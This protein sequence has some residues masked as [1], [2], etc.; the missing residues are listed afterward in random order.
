MMKKLSIVLLALLASLL[1][2][3]AQNVLSNASFET[4]SVHQ[5]GTGATPG[6]TTYGTSGFQ[7][8]DFARTGTFSVKSWWDDSGIFQDFS[9]TAGLTYNVSAYGYNPTGDAAIGKDGALRIEWFDGSFVQI[10]TTT[11][12]GKFF[13]DGVDPLNTWKLISGSVVAPA[14]AVNGRIVLGVVANANPMQGGVVGWD[15]ASVSLAAVPE[16]S[17]MAMM[18][19]GLVG[20]FGAV[21]RFRK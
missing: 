2:A 7:E 8:T 11:T 3:G 13:G 20:L 4:G 1:P 5:Y 21:R 16:L 19:I 18:G 17:S 15:D 9:A 12:V 6:W 14:G 10:G